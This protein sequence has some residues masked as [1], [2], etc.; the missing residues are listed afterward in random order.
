MLCLPTLQ[1][2]RHLACRILSIV[3]CQNV[4]QSKS[5]RSSSSLAFKRQVRNSR[6]FPVERFHKHHFGH[7]LD[8]CRPATRR[9]QY[10]N[11]P[12]ICMLHIHFRCTWLCFFKY[13]FITWIPCLERAQI[14]RKYCRASA[15]MCTISGLTRA[16]ESSRHPKL[17][18]LLYLHCSWWVQSQSWTL[19]SCLIVRITTSV[20]SHQ[21]FELSFRPSPRKYQDV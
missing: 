3:Y 4:C 17:S 8:Y 13:G 19:G 2:S 1:A 5:L 12:P 9:Y 6:T 18:P 7:T 16:E 20:S 11:Y 21:K 14:L 15:R 10:S